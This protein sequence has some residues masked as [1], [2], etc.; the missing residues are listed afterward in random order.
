MILQAKNAA[1]EKLIA[2][3]I[4][5][6]MKSLHGGTIAQ[7]LAGAKQI[8]RSVYNT[9]PKQLDRFN[10]ETSAFLRKEASDIASTDSSYTTPG[11]DDGRDQAM[12]DCLADGYTQAQCDQ[13]QSEL[14]PAKSAAGEYPTNSYTT[15]GDKVTTNHFNV[16]EPQSKYQ[17]KQQMI[18]ALI[19]QGLSQAAATTAAEA[20]FGP[21]NNPQ[22]GKVFAQAKWNPTKKL[23]DKGFGLAQ[24]T[25]ITADVYGG[26]NPEAVR[27]IKQT[28][29]HGY[30]G[31]RSTITTKIPQR[32][33]IKQASVAEIVPWAVVSA[34]IDPNETV[35]F[36]NGLRSASQ[37]PA[38]YFPESIADMRIR[39]TEEKESRIANSN[40]ILSAKKDS[41]PAW[42][43]VSCADLI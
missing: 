14:Y 13:M 4:A 20:V 37:I 29:N 6:I 42:A 5:T 34:D 43:R 15:T 9:S 11:K 8:A 40:R 19:A 26:P 17:T 7:R 23:V 2:A 12:K 32:G 28:T 39:K 18:A 30:G 41:V 27:T 1:N 24:A 33:P 31:G 36:D 10:A 3:Q 16:N 21:G 35:T 22:S 25:K 38:H